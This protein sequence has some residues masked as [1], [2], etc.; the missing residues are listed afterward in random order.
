MTDS[1]EH[2]LDALEIEAIEIDCKEAKRLINRAFQ[3]LDEDNRTDAIRCR[4][5]AIHFLTLH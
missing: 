5:R 4:N 3:S 1:L 2:E